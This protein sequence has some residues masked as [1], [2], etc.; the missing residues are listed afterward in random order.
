MSLLKRVQM[1]MKKMH[2]FRKMDGSDKMKRIY[3]EEKR[4]KYT[5][6]CAS[7]HLFLCKR[8]WMGTLKD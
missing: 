8:Y 4:F 3:E 2:Y 1:I 7:M 6:K 5:E